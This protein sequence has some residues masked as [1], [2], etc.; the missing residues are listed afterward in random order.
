MIIM[1]FYRKK[2]KLPTHSHHTPPPPESTPRSITFWSV[3]V[4]S[5]KSALSK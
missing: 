1:G 3:P 5:S 2:Q 4:P